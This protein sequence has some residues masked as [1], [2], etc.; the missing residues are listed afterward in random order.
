MPLRDVAAAGGW[1]DPTT[2]LKCYQQPDEETMRRVVLEAPKLL[3]QPVRRLEVT[4]TVTPDEEVDPP[5]DQR[6]AG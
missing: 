3:S 5:E 2:L 6:N 1:R 4:P